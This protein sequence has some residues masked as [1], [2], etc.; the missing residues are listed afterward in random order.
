[1]SLS[2]GFARRLDDLAPR[3][4]QADA[5]EVDALVDRRR[6]EG[7]VALHAVAHRAG[8]HLAVGDVVRA[9]AG[10]DADVLD[11]KAQVR[12]RPGDLDLVRAGHAL[13]ERFHAGD[14]PGVVE[15]ADAEV[16]VLEGFRTHAG[17][18]GHGRGGPAQHAPAGFLD[19][20]V[21]DRA[22]ELH[23]E[24]HLVAGHVAH[25]GDV[26]AAADGDVGLHLLHAGEFELGHDGVLGLVGVAEHLAGDARLVDGHQR[27]G[28]GGAGGADERD[29]HG[30]GDVEA[31]EQDAVALLEAGGEAGEVAGELVVTWVTHGGRNSEVIHRAKNPGSKWVVDKLG[32]GGE[33]RA[34][35]KGATIARP[36]RVASGQVAFHRVHRVHR[37]TAKTADFPRFPSFPKAT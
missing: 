19:P 33:E 23:G 17:L 14:H 29:G 1:M 4:L 13:L 18:L 31:V 24:V 3:E 26:V 30:L 6:V 2:S 34:V 10:D 37:C 15:R 28:P 11:G 22:H 7:D 20:V 35:K 21:D 27:Q 16:E 12:A 8:E 9:P 25:L 32:K 5:V 36:R